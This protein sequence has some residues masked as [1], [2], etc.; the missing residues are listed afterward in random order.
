MFPSHFFF[1]PGPPSLFMLKHFAFLTVT[2]SA[3]LTISIKP[4]NMQNDV[5]MIHQLVRFQWFQKASG[6]LK[7]EGHPALSWLCR[8]HRTGEEQLLGSQ[9]GSLWFIVFI[10]LIP[11]VSGQNRRLL[12]QWLS[13]ACAIPSEMSSPRGFH[14]LSPD[15][16][17]SLCKM[18]VYSQDLFLALIS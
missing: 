4:A 10:V 9:T 17:S 14:T 6:I 2:D 18:R 15:S 1:S 3:S 5:L 13:N 8:G 12:P 11:A 7:L 16:L